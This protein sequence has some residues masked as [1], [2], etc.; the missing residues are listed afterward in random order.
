MSI[1][2]FAIPPYSLKQRPNSSHEAPPRGEVF[3]PV[4]PDEL[5]FALTLFVAVANKRIPYRSLLDCDSLAECKQIFRSLSGN[6]RPPPKLRATDS[7]RE[8]SLQVAFVALWQHTQHQLL[9][10]SLCTR[11]LAFYLLMERT[12]GEL[13]QDWMELCPD[14]PESV[15]LDPAVINALAFV[16]LNQLGSLDPTLFLDTIEL[17]SR[18]QAA[19]G[20]NCG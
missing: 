10:R 11:V 5:G 12:G 15:A 13:L 9:Q 6:H 18:K 16:P 17:M 14:Q 1:L 3:V 2:S 19:E 8:S 7:D 20:A 4:N